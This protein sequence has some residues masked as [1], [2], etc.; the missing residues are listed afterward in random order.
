VPALTF[1]TSRGGDWVDRSVAK[2]IGMP[3]AQVC[4][5][6]E[7]GMHLYRPEDPVEGAVAIYY[8]HLLQDLF[9]TFRRKIGESEWV[10]SFTKPVDIV[11]A[12]GPPWSAGSSRCSGGAGQGAAADRGGRRPAREQPLETVV[13]GCLRRRRRRPGRWKRSGRDDAPVRDRAASTSDDDSDG[14]SV[15][16]ALPPRKA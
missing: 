8:R 15:P 4:A 13:A 1:S 12:G 9:E 14:A 11:C 16:P 7:R 6:K 3:E 10:P 5:V 2:A